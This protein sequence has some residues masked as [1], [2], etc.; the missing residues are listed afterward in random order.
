MFRIPTPVLG[1]GLIEAIPD[2]AILANMANNASQN[3]PLGVKGH[4]NA[5]LG[6]NT[7]LS[8]ND[9]TVTRLAGRRRTNLY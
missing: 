7:N 4:A 9:G 6:G 2:S 8:A 5:I 3:A 1:T